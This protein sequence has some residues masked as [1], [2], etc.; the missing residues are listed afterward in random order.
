MFDDQ[1]FVF[2]RAWCLGRNYHLALNALEFG[3]K[4]HTGLRKNGAPEYHHQLSISHYL[5]TFIGHLEFPEETLAAAFLHDVCEDYDVGFDE[6]QSKFGNKIGTAV[7]LLTKKYR[8]DK[9]PA[10]VYYK[11]LA[12]DPIASVVKGADRVNN[13][14]TMI[15]VFSLEKQKAYIDETENLVLPM[16]KSARRQF[17][18]QESAYENEKMM[19]RSQ[20]ELIQAIHASSESKEI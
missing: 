8:G 19:I 18:M 7:S 20:L 9:I 5:R 4:F 1:K 16:L 12:K 17:T 14:Q 6:I 13:I 2:I 15:G 10:E 11:D 3:A